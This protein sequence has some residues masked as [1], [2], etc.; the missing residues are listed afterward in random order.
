MPRGPRIDYPGLLHH[1]IVRGIERREIFTKEDDYEDFINRLEE[2]LKNSGAEVFAWVLMPNHFHLLIRI[3][4][5]PLT[6]IMRGLL[7]GYALSYNRKHKRVGYLYQGRYKS[8]ACE[9][10]PYL[11]ELVRYIHLN[12]LR[13]NLVKTPPELDRYRWSG[14][15]VIMGNQ[16]VSW[17]NTQEILSR[18]GRT[19]TEARRKYR[20]FVIEGAGQDRREELMG[21][22]L[23]RSLGGIGKAILAGLTNTVYDQRILG[24]GDFVEGIMKKIEQ[25]EGRIPKNKI[26][27]DELI[28]RV[29]K[30]Y[31]IKVENVLTNKKQRGLSKP[32][33]IIIRI[34]IDMLGLSGSDLGRKLSVSK[35][36]VSKLNKMGE[37][38]IS[39]EEGIPKEILGK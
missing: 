2:S 36:W 31:N 38:V 7:T 35:S 5:K 20:E 23:I 33:A 37:E 10:E 16:K 14:H 18:F 29:C 8:I 27:I 3:G 21:G 4:V 32:R 15:S 19:E 30:Y 6:S 17:Q 1:V 39:K 25:K 26:E 13:A 9:E 11:L 34:G 22:G 28:H 24:G 12:P